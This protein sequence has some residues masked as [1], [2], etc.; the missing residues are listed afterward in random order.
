MR[1]SSVKRLVHPAGAACLLLLVPLLLG[2]C[3]SSSGRS[4]RHGD[5]SGS[6]A[7]TTAPPS[8]AGA[9]PSGSSGAASA[10]VLARADL[11]GDG[12]T[13]VVR[14]RASDAACPGVLLARVGGRLMQAQISDDGPPVVSAFAVHVPG[15]RGD[16]LVTRQVHPRGGFQARVF[17]ADGATLTEL[18]VH[19]QPLL[20]FVATDVS[21]HPWS[22]DCSSQRLTFTEAV[23]HQPPGVA[24]AWDVRRTS[25]ALRGGG[26]GVV[27]PGATKRVQ[28][29]VLP[30][31]L[32]RRYPDLLAHRLFA[33]CR[34]R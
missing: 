28:D 8:S 34:T 18:R 23:A 29:D 7:P 9:C 1:H 30:G 12:R 27:T 32:S 15:R 5:G 16:L 14:L 31:E 26:G 11:D 4:E 19:G 25:Y 6:S 21:E 22:I 17:V 20:P 13:E 24:L 33:S 2:G 10:K 3:G